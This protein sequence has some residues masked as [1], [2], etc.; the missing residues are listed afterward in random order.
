MTLWY[1]AHNRCPIPSG[2]VL[3]LEEKR[4]RKSEM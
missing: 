4:N 3:E 1:V 2:L